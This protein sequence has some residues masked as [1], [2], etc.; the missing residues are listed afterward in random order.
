M[1]QRLLSLSRITFFFAL[2]IRYIWKTLN[3]LRLTYK[4]DFFHPL[5]QDILL[6]SH[7]FWFQLVP[8]IRI[9]YN[10]RKY[11]LWLFSCFASRDVIFLNFVNFFGCSLTNNASA[12]SVERY[13]STSNLEWL[14][15]K[16]FRCLVKALEGF[17]DKPKWEYISWW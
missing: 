1:G 2:V 5:S 8:Q 6:F 13:K 4:G 16:S 7:K 15:F 14:H 12:E 3:P 17:C 10:W 11:Y 9:L